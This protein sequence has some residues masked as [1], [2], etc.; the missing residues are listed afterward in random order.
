MVA[1][2]GCGDVEAPSEFAKG[3]SEQVRLL[4]EVERGF[5]DSLRSETHV[6]W[7][8]L[9]RHAFLPLATSDLGYRRA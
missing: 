7:C 5:D 8:C 6:K 2:D 9:V 4:G 1:D 3:S